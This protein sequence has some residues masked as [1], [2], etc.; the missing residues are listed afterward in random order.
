MVLGG[1]NA[2][3]MAIVAAATFEILLPR[4]ATSNWRMPA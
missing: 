3:A 4:A 2:L 1:V